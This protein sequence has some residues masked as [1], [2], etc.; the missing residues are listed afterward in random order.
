MQTL[1]LFA[2]VNSD[3][4]LRCLQLVQNY[5]PSVI[6][7]AVCC[8]LKSLDKIIFAM[9]VEDEDEDFRNYISKKV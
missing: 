6:L 5:L 9:K 4:F 1:H 3:K 2:D 7:I 8:I